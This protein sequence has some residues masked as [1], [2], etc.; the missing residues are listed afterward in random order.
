MRRAPRGRDI[1]GLAW[2]SPVYLGIS[3]VV[4]RVPHVCGVKVPG[5]FS[6]SGPKRHKDQLLVTEQTKSTIRT[7]TMRAIASLSLHVT[8]DLGIGAEQLQSYLLIEHPTKT[9]PRPSK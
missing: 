4:S 2:A 5:L 9:P 7:S 8:L 3:H 6:A 1:W